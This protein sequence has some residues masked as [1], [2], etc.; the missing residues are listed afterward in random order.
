VTFQHDDFHPANLIAHDG[1]LCGVIDF[2]RY[3]WGDPVEE[4][5]KLA[6]FGVP[7]SLTFAH[8][9]VHGY[10]QAGPVPNFWRRYTLYTAMSVNSSLAWAHD[11]QPDRMPFWQ[12][13]L[14]AVAPTLDLD[15]GG[16]PTWYADC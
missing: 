13:L 11:H 6:Y 14:T 8:G 4:F 15:A 10:L 5:Y 12:D 9:Q 2:D 1:R 7:L 3:D 16:P